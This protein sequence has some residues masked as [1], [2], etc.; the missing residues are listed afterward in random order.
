[1]Q[2]LK[3]KFMEIVDLAQTNRYDDLWSETIELISTSK[4]KLKDNYLSLDPRSFLSFTALIHNGKIICFSAL[5]S[6]NDRWGEDIVRCSARMWV[7]PDHR[8]LGL[9]RFTQGKKFLNSYYLIPEQIK[10]AKMLGYRCIFMSREENPLAFF[11][12]SDLVNRNAGSG[13]INLPGRYNVCGNL[14]P[15]PESCKQYVSI[16]TSNSQSLPIWHASMEKFRIKED[17]T[18]VSMAY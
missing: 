18:H 13:F 5:Q 2:K 15:I 1:M 9:T 16:D 7:H 8:F 11:K 12:W 14:N 10:K 4:D 3:K 6:N 17:L